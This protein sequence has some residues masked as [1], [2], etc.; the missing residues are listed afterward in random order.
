M[1]YDEN[2]GSHVAWGN[3]FPLALERGTD[4]TPQ[5]RIDSGVNQAA[6]HVDI[7][8]GSPDV[9]IDGIHADGTAVAITRG[10]QF[11]LGSA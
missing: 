5:Q 7:V 4:L 6:T 11:V 2:V 9:E 1:L 3:G 10:D 8:V